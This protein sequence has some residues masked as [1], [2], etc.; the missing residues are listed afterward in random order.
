MKKHKGMRPLD[1]V[2]LARIAT[3]EGSW[4]MKDI[5]R[6]LKISASE[7]SESLHRSSVVGLLSQDKRRINF[8]AFMEFLTHGLKYTFPITLGESCCGMRVS[9]PAIAKAEGMAGM[10]YVWTFEKGDVMGQSIEPLHRNVPAVCE[11]DPKFCKVMILI[12]FLRMGNPKYFVLALRELREIFR[13]TGRF[14]V[15]KS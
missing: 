5:A 8:A 6:D 7:V 13:K 4:R 15:D 2:I 1:V 3:Q 11:E 12:E 9:H 10:I 14:A